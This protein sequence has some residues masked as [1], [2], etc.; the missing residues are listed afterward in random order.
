MATTV[1][2]LKQRM[3]QLER[4][5]TSLREIVNELQPAVD[6]LPPIRTREWLPG[7][8]VIDGESARAHIDRAFEKMGIDVTQPAL[9][10]EE[11]QQLM[12]QEGVRPEDCILS[13]GIIEAREE[14]G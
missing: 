10:A 9:S 12:L 13:R 2:E 3:E 8:R 6:G 7:I 4:E 5:V 11:I 1:E 14:R